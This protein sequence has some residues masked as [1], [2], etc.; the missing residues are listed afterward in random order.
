ML[1]SVKH[2]VSSKKVTTFAVSK[3]KNN[4][5]KQFKTLRSRGQPLI[6]DMTKFIGNAFSIQMVKDFPATVKVTECSKAEALAPDNISVVD[7]QDTANVLGVKYNRANLKLYK[8]D[9]LYVAQIVGGRLPEGCT[10][11]PK[12]FLLKFFKVT[13]K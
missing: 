3:D 6:R 9:V 11:L 2:F 8:K 10:T 4:I 12:G 1:K 7:H 5:I 13:V